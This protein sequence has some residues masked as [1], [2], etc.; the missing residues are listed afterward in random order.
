MICWIPSGF[1]H[2]KK[3]GFP[4][5]C[6]INSPLLSAS[7]GSN[8]DA[9]LARQIPKDN[10]NHGWRQGFQLLRPETA[11]VDSSVFRRLQLAALIPA[12]RRLNQAGR[13]WGQPWIQSRALRENILPRIAPRLFANHVNALCRRILAWYSSHRYHQQRGNSCGSSDQ[14]T[15]HSSCVIWLYCSSKVSI[16]KDLIFSLTSSWAVEFF[17]TASTPTSLIPIRYGT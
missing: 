15:G 6:S 13:K 17:E 2:D 16:F 11:S 9:L 1:L 3:S 7:I 5:F 8:L 12:E 14:L 4:G 10:T